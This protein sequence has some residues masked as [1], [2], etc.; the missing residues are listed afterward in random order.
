MRPVSAAFGRTI[1]GS[2]RAVMVA[3]VPDTTL[4]T[5]VPTGTRIPIIGGNVRLD[6]TADI[7]G[8]L[9]LTTVGS[10]WPKDSADLLAPYGQEIFVARGVAYSDLVYEYAALGY[11]RIDSP[12][13]D[14]PINGPIRITGSDRMAG[15]KDAQLLSPGQFTADQTVGSVVA[16]LIGDVYPAAVIV[17][18]SGQT[19]PLGVD[20]VTTE[21]R[22]AFLNDLITS[23]GK[24]WYWDGLGVL[25]IRDVPDAGSPVT[26]VVVGR[27]GILV[28]TARALTRSG[29]YNAVVATGQATTTGSASGRG[30]AM[31]TDPLSPTRW[32]GPF[33]KVPL[34]YTST[35][36]ADDGQAIAAARA[37]LARYKGLPYTLNLTLSPNPALEPWDPVRTRIASTEGRE[38]HVIES[39]TIPLTADGTMAATTRQQTRVLRS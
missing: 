4:P 18:D 1:S 8:T 36:I 14:Q 21:D 6:G 12:S 10:L 22:H 24:I 11:Y 9:D 5:G 19:R 28:G 37:Q 2:H 3:I 17:W 23:L 35:A 31:D 16:T 33:G 30:V 34:F 26:D 39:L 27:D 38:I 25:Q 13:Q 32:G 20:S 7:R 29:V 15:I